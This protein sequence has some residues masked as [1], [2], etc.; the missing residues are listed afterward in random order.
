MVPVVPSAFVNVLV[1]V[2]VLVLFVVLSELLDRFIEAMPSSFRVN[3]SPSSLTPSLSIS[4][5]TLTFAKFVSFVSNLPSPFVSSEDS[6]LNPLVALA[7]FT[8][9]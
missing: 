4:L 8:T 2:I 7:P 1:A 9:V 6:A 5:Q 3:N